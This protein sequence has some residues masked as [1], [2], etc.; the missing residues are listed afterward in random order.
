M[1][2]DYHNRRGGRR[3][4]DDYDYLTKK[5]PYN[6]KKEYSNQIMPKKMYSHNVYIL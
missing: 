5:K 3:F 4:H 2:D 6:G 1:I